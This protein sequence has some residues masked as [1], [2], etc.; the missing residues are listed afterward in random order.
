MM[1]Q[2][3]TIKTGNCGCFNCGKVQEGMKM[4]PFT[5]YQKLDDEKRGHNN[6][7][8]SMECAKA[9]VEKLKANS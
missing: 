1:I 6:P 7:V 2:I 9:Y 8:C 4:H 3:K 5:V